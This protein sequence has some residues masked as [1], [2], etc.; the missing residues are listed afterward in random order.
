MSE[1]TILQVNDSHG[2]LDLHPELFWTGDH[3]AYRMAGGYGRLASL[4]KEVRRESPG[5][6]LLFDCGD[7]IH[8]THAA[9]TTRGEA[10]VPILNAIGFDAMTA[11]WEFAYGPDRLR[12]IA[13]RLDYPLLA[14]NCYDQRTNQRVFEPYTLV[15][16]GGLQVGVIG[17]A[18]TIVDKTMPASFSEGVYFTLGNQELPGLIRHLRDEEKVDLVILIS[19]LG[20]PQEMKLAREID[21]IDVLLSGHTHN[22]VYRPACVNDTIVIQSGCHGSFLGRLDLEIDGGRVADVRHQ[23]ITVSEKIGPDPEVQPLVED[24]LRP[25]DAALGEVVGH[26]STALNRYTVL[27]ATMDN[28]L[29]QALQSLTGAQLAFS[30]GWRYGAPVVPGPVTLNDL[31]NII[32]VNPPVSV[33]RISGDELWSM[34][35]QNLEHTFSR[36][37][38]RQMGGYLKRCL[39]LNLYAKIENPY[40]ERIQELFVG[41]ERVLPDRLYDATFVTSQG[42]PDGYGTDREHLDVTAIDALRR[43]L[44]AHDPA[45]SGLRGTIVAV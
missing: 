19:H 13:A 21:G 36:D 37:P 10:L 32:P 5:R 41:G 26:V 24:V 27:E 16:A 9:V 23:L 4:V 12:E 42:V 35:E 29:L 18:A 45:E 44:S 30:N 8:G 20:F 17:L 43:Y 31:W 33:C 38:Y 1:L 25:H 39:G 28:L 40:G 7:T 3:A 34:M 6:T 22:R 14:V 11:H 2:Y 15:Q